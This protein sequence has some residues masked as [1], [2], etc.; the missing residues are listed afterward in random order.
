MELSSI[1]SPDEPDCYITN[2]YT[3]FE[4]NIDLDPTLFSFEPPEGYA[5]EKI[6]Y[7]LPS[8]RP[9]PRDLIGALRLWAEMSE[10]EFPSTIDKLSEIQYKKL[11]QYLDEK[12]YSDQKHKEAITIVDNG[13]GQG[14]RKDLAN[15]T[16][17][18][19]E[20]YWVMRM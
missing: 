9:G 6:Q 3:D 15:G 8:R 20:Y 18:E 12:L 1:Q 5:V 16:T 17:M 7:Q 11:D 10:G 4:W 2:V 19:Q 13:P 14:C